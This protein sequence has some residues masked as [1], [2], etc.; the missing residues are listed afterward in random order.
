MVYIDPELEPRDRGDYRYDSRAASRAN[1]LVAGLRDGLS[2]Y[3]G[4][5]SGLPQI[6]IPAGPTLRRGDS[7]ER[8]RL[9]RHRLGLEEEGEFDRDLALEVESY[10]RAHGLGSG[11]HADAKTIA[12]LNL[13]TAHYERIILANLERARALPADPGERYILVDAAAARLWLYEDGEAVDTM[14]VIVG[15]ESEHTQTPMLAGLIRYAMVNP[16]WNVPPDLVRDKIA[17]G[18]LAEGFGYLRARRYEILS[19]WTEDASVLAPDEV[20]WEAIADGRE[21]LR[22][23]QLPGPDNGM[24]QIKFMFPNRF[25]VYLHDTPDKSL[26]EHEERRFSSGC[27]RLEDARRLARWLFGEMPRGAS[28]DREER[29]DLKEPVP[30]YITYFTAAPSGDGIVFRDDPYGRDT[31]LLARLEYDLGD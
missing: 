4:R 22:V 31:A 9:L 1:S 18:V 2:E 23:R 6:E 12:S 13:G 15:K 5:W 25:G 16:Y 28:P 3:R 19:D 26:F 29:V 14:R 17:P 8:V 24:G 7:G 11:A 30:V 20:D 27:V 21:E 10:R